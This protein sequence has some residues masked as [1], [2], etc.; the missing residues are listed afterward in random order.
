[1][2]VETQTGKKIKYLRTTNDLEFCNNDFDVMCVKFGITGHKTVLY[3]LQQNG[4]VERMNRTLLDKVRC[5][6]LGSGI[7]K[8]F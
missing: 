4:V 3:T 7:L 5:M 8:S 1:M 6:M 2:L